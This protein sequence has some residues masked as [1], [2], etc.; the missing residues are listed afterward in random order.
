M[1][2]FIKCYIEDFDYMV[3]KEEGWSIRANYFTKDSL[4]IRGDKCK[5]F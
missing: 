5:E 1:F 2:E 4:L 3:S